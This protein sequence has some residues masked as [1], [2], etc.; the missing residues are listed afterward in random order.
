M[1]ENTSSGTLDKPDAVDR[2]MKERDKKSKANAAECL[3]STLT[4]A[5]L[6]V[7]DYR[8]ITRR[9]AVAAADFKAAVERRGERVRSCEFRVA[10]C[11]CSQAN[12]PSQL[13]RSDAVVAGRGLLG[14]RPLAVLH[15]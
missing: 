11:P 6:A 12:S 5:L 3:A 4:E 1:I 13:A 14:L 8:P 9:I 10:S 15:R 2:W 7:N